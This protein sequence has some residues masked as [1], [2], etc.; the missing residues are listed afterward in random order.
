MLRNLRFYLSSLVVTSALFQTGPLFALPPVTA[1]TTLSTPSGVSCSGI[2]CTISN[3]TVS[4][5]ALFHS[6]QTFSIPSNGSVSFNNALSITH[7]IARV[8]GNSASNIDGLLTANGTANLFLINPQGIF[9]GPN[10][11][12]NLG[13]SFLATTAN[14]IQLPNGTEFSATNPQDPPLLNVSTPLGL[15]FG[16][17]NGPIQVNGSPLTVLPGRTLALVGGPVSI[18]SGYLESLS[19]RVEIGG[20]GDFSTVK[21]NPSGFGFALDYGGVSAFRDVSLNAG[22]VVNVSG[23]GG[24]QIQLAGDRI[25]LQNNSRLLALTLGPLS[26]GGVKIKANTSLEMIGTGGYQQT[27]AKFVAGTVTVN[28]LKDGIFT[29]TQ[30]D[31]AAGTIEIET[32]QFSSRNGALISASTFGKGRGGD[33]FLN[34]SKSVDL[35]A[36]F[37]A[38]GTGVGDAGRAG[39]L[40]LKTQRFFASD[41][42][43]LTTSSFGNG[44]GGNLFMT[45]TDSLEL[46]G[47]TPFPL[48]PDVRLVTGFYSSA[49]ASGNAGDLQVQTGR[50]LI[51]NGAGIAAS[52]FGAGNGGNITVKA[53]ESVTV[54]GRSP[55]DAT[56]SSIAVV[57]EPIATGQSGN[58]SVEAPLIHLENGGRISVRSRGTGN[59]GTLSARA[60]VM[61]LNQE[62]L[63]EGTAISGEGANI[64]L[65]ARDYIL[66]RHNSQIATNAEGTGNGGNITIRAPFIIAVPKENSDIIA[67]AIRG[68]G[69]NISITTQRIYGLKFSRFLTPESDINASSEFG[70]S[71]VVQINTSN[72]DPNKGLE[73]LPE[74]L[75]EVA[76]LISQSCQA[77]GRQNRFV[78]TGR[79]GLPP[80]P[81]D[82]LNEEALAVGWVEIAPNRDRPNLDHLATNAV[83]EAL[84][85]SPVPLEAQGWARTPEGTI[86]LTAA[87]PQTI[88]NPQPS[89]SCQEILE[90]ITANQPE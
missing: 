85:A 56:F 70:V 52:T 31:G 35:Q 51:R 67:N 36:S 90:K 26:G 55:N 3:G 13:G 50:L 37:I 24:G 7:I 10:T 17:G 71:G 72:L 78:M 1:D 68:R 41:N 21:I 15:Q 8:T 89:K 46:V 4:G 22:S 34:A 80:S 74:N 14:A 39:D 77:D 18:Q 30:G 27:M 33:V 64:N 88:A 40:V 11:T 53:S 44:Q 54:T 48:P 23:L 6:F 65:E 43:V 47:T 81:R 82:T 25:T 20:V 63:F 9:F 5:N 62:A 29:F 32:Q 69:G 45:A 49:L 38:T 12:L 16:S 19:G 58:L 2:H 76:Q 42:A 28:D 57:T 59:G 60:N 73:N 87:L 61:I 75:V 86:T 84:P 83:T 79:G 66:L